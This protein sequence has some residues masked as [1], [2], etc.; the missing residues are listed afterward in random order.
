[1]GK[2][3]K[4]CTSCD[5]NFAEKFSFCPNCGKSMQAFELNPV[6]AATNAALIVAP[7]TAA[8]IE[9]PKSVEA[10]A[11]VSTANGN[12]KAA[13]ERVE[14]VS[15][16]QTAKTETVPFVSS[17]LKESNFN[18]A[19]L[20]TTPPVVETKT[21]AATT[22]NS[23]GNGYKSEAASV[24]GYRTVES[25]NYRKADNAFNVTVIEDKNGKQR[26]MLL[27]GSLLLM[28]TVAAGAMVYS[29][30]NYNLSVAA[31]GDESGL[32]VPITDEVPM[33]VEETPKPK[34]DKDAGGGGGGGRDE[35][36]P[37]SQ[38]KLANQTEKPIIAPDKSIV[39]KDFELKQP[40]AST[41]GNKTFPPSPLPYGDPNA[42]AGLTSSN[43]MGTG[44]GQGSGIG[45][46]QGSGRGTGAGSGAGSG[47]GAGEGTGNGN[48]KGPGNEGAGR[49][50]A[51][52][53]AP[54][55]PAPV[56]PSVGVTITSK[57]RANYTDAARQNQLQGTVTL[58]VT[59]NANG[60]IGGITPVN[61]LGMGLTEQAIAA[62]RG[63]RFEPAKKNGVP[64]TVT[65]QVQ[66]SFT[67]Y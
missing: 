14:T 6:A 57:P 24:D 28:M 13:S 21:F 16:I 66:Y 50:P 60:T 53:P 27:L 61:G 3:V 20:D 45:T 42:R 44:G 15:Q 18:T 49:V 34:N 63:I 26:N 9:T 67:I 41:Q 52:P 47:Y 8:R 54:K 55:P 39:Q 31:I 12:G 32:S 58:R 29:L 17:Q 5:E 2:I 30:F 22:A 38:G 35:P 56:G 59:F 64:Q 37:T 25:S 23:N 65:K 19:R 10:V 62:A 36:T 33:E 1:M 48:G 43:G 4:H 40:I 46:G 51:P 11:P 7:E